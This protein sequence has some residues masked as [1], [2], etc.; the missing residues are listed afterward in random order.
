MRGHT[1]RQPGK[2]RTQKEQTGIYRPAN[3]S[4]MTISL[5]LRK[6]QVMRGRARDAL[7]KLSS[8]NLAGRSEKLL[9]LETWPRQNINKNPLLA[10]PV[11][12]D[13]T[14]TAV[15]R[16]FSAR[17]SA[18]NSS[19]NPVLMITGVTLSTCVWWVRLRYGNKADLELGCQN[20]GLKSCIVVD[21]IS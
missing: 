20:L 12:K 1:P 15:S 18:S 11:G 13:R 8:G 6:I 21:C 3:T 7:T 16:Q 4:P 17:A 19:V 14:S 10:H 9:W 2:A 5:C